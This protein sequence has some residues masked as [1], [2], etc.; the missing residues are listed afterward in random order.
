MFMGAPGIILPV[1]NGNSGSQ[2]TVQGFERAFQQTRLEVTATRSRFHLQ[3]GGVGLV[4]E[5]FS[6]VEPGDLRR[7]SIPMSYI[8]LTVQS[9]DGRA[10]DVQLYMDISGEWASGDV[11]QVINWAPYSDASLRAWTVQLAS[12]QPL[13]EQGQLAAWGTVVWATPGAPGVSYQSGQDIVVRGQFVAH[14]SLPDSDDTNYR[15]ISDNWPVF[16]FCRDLGQVGG[17]PVTVPLSIGQV[18]TPAVSYLGQDLKPLWSGYFSG[19]QDMAGF[20]S[21]TWPR[22][23]AGPTSW[24]AGST[25]TR[26]PRAAGATRACARSR[27]GRR[28]AGPSC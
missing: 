16:A 13:T 19:W 7:Q 12:Q 17:S 25:A 2:S 1:P 27:C 21:P 14:G 11:G 20:S 4:T 10:H 28:T 3:G 9:L 18:R 8:L 24:T 23:A 26:P 6:P 15:A 5:F 22:P